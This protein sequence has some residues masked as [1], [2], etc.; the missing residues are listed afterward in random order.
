MS[1]LGIADMKQFALPAG[2]DAGELEKYRTADGVT[3]EDIVNDILAGLQVVGGD[4]IG[5]PKYGTLAGLTTEQA[6]EYSNGS[7]DRGMEERTEYRP[8]DPKRGT[9]IGHMLPLNGYDRSLAWTWDFLDVARRV[10]IDTDI[11]D[12]RGS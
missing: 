6:F 1:V 3:Y 10:Q 7:T 9:T 8:A 12:A 11:S 2:F 4:L 5:H